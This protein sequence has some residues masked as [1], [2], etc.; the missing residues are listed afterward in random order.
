MLTCGEMNEPQRIGFPVCNRVNRAISSSHSPQT[1]SLHRR[2]VGHVCFMRQLILISP[3]ANITG[4][5]S[6]I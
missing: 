4:E 6:C 1:L 5:R 2:Y 3:H